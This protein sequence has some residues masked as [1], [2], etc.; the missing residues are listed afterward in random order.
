MVISAR[1]VGERCTGGRYQGKTS[2]SEFVVNSL[3]DAQRIQ[4]DLK[5]VHLQTPG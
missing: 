1:K 3:G 2:V 5:P 4:C